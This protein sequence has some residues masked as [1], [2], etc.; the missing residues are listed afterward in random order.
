MLS[1]E[2][3]KIPQGPFGEAKCIKQILNTKKNTTKNQTSSEAKKT[4]ET[5]QTITLK[6]T[7]KTHT[8]NKNQQ[9]K[10][11]PNKTSLQNKKTSPKTPSR[12]HL[13]GVAL[14]PRAVI[15]GAALHTLTTTIGVAKAR[16]IAPKP[17]GG[18]SFVGI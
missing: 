2:Q 1:R 12:L 11:E 5:I 18:W 6:K 7:T 4:P 3:K 10:S 9:K 13:L 17:Q 14:P 16:D 15:Q 8:T